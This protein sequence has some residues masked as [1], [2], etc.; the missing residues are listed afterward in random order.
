MIDQL[1]GYSDAMKKKYDIVAALGMAELGDEEL[2]QKKPVV[3][4]AVKKQ[5]RDIG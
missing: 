2:S 5:F 3:R 4:E 1:L